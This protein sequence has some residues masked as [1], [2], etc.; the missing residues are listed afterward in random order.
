[1]KPQLPIPDD[2]ALSHS[3]ALRDFIINAISKAP[4]QAISFADYMQMALYAPGLGYYS[5]GSKKLGSDGDFTTAPE[6][7][8]LFG[9]CIANQCATVFESLNTNAAILEL[10][11]G[12]GRLAKTILEQLENL[13]QLPEKY[14]ILDVSPDLKQKQQEFLQQNLSATLFE[15]CI[16]L[17]ALPEQFTGVII[18]NEVLDA[19]AVRRFVWSNQQ[20]NEVFVTYADSN[21]K[22]ILVPADNDLSQ[23]IHALQQTYGHDWPEDYQ[24]EINIQMDGLVRSLAASLTQGMILLIDYGFPGHEYYHPQRHTGTLVCHYRH[25]VHNDPYFYPGLQDITAHVDFTRVAEIAQ[26]S[27]LTIAGFTTQ[28]GFL[29]GSGLM[30]ITPSE[31]LGEQM[32]INQQ[33]QLLT[34]PAEMGELFKVIGLTKQCDA[35]LN[36]VDFLSRML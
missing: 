13:N 1:M 8:P 29:L 28:A 22:E 21:F 23:R 10:G 3:N 35:S 14:F 24:S 26:E 34:S 20:N 7:S 19:L 33:I 27:G 15:R 18:A 2:E 11:A 12:T 30:S 31:N 9:T 17:N 32:K 25:H 16:W 36:Q 5:A 6:I 4:N